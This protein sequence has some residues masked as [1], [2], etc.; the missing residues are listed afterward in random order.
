MPFTQIGADG[1]LLRA[2]VELGALLIAPGERADVIVDFAGRRGR[3]FIV[4]NNARAPVSDGWAGLA[5]AAG[6]VPGPAAAAGHGRHAAAADLELPALA[7]L[8]DP[9]VTRVQH[10]SETLDELTGAPI[11]LNVE[12]APYLT[13]AASRR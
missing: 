9:S 7:F 10:L 2:P 1:G 11:T 4:T 3:S 13:A 5:L 8:P 12:D 6:E